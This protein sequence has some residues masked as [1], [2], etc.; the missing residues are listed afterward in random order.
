MYILY[1][2]YIKC[3]GFSFASLAG[4]RV[5]HFRCVGSTWALPRALAPPSLKPYWEA[6]IGPKWAHPCCQWWLFHIQHSIQ[7][8]DC[9]LY[10]PTAPTI[11]ALDV[12][13]L[14]LNIV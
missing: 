7:C 10:W 1:T 5:M 6:Y 2:M 8:S 13:N 14:F 3:N 11:L 12:N 4:L 9:L